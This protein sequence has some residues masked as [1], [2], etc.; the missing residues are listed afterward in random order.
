MGAMIIAETSDFSH[1]DSTDKIL[2]YVGMSLFTYPSEQLDNCYSH[3]EK[4]G[5]RYL[6]YAPTMQLNILAIG[7]N[8]LA[9]TLIKNV[10]KVS[11]IMLL[12][13]MLQKKLARTI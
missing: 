2:A 10:P 11:I 6:R 13:P 8:P 1:F 7:T 4:R 9:F 5:S 3:M 12:Y